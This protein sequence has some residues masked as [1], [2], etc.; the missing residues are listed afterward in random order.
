MQ[1]GKPVVP[2][3]FAL[4]HKQL[5]RVVDWWREWEGSGR[6]RLSRADFRK[7]MLGVGV[8]LEH[9]GELHTLYGLLGEVRGRVPIVI[10]PC[11]MMPIPITPCLMVPIPITPCLV[12]PIVLAPCLMLPIPITPSLIAP[13]DLAPCL[14]VPIVTCPDCLT[15][16]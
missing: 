5:M 16:T 12:A 11:S 4:L 13:I 7:G 9:V 3:L 10:T 6:G 1:P 14:M 2:Q 15:R 8:E